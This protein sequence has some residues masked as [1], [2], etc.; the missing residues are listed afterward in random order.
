MAGCTLITVLIFGGVPAA[1]A[2][3]TVAQQVAT[4]KLGRKIKVEL[5]NSE[6]VK[7]RMGSATADQFILEPDNAAHGAARTI[8]F[9]DARSVKSDGMTTSGKWIMW[10]I[11]VFAGLGIVGSRV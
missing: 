10:V 7:G 8:Q 6:T 11:I 3:L 2:D 9:V 1:A 5:N 4:L